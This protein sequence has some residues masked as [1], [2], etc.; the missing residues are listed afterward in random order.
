VLTPHPG[1]MARLIG[2]TPAEVQAGRLA[3]ATAYAK[4]T[5]S[6]VVLKGAC[7]IVAAPDG[8][9]RLSSFANPV[10]AHAGTGDVLAGLI[11][12]LI[13][14]GLEPFDAASA[15]VYLH[16]DAGRLVAEASGSASALAQDLLGA[17]ATTRKLLDGEGT[18]DVPWPL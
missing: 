12:G 8:R 4:E 2:S 6:T 3:C 9:A 15:A 13:A 16:S 1:E 11:G 5:G 10:L 14:Q 17:L 7:T 18:S